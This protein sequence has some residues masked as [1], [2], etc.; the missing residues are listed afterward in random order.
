MAVWALGINHHTAPLDLRG[1]F[2]F[3]LDQIAPTLHGLR[4]SLSSASGRHPGVETAIISTCNRTEIYCAAEAPALDHTLDWL[5]H[6][7]GVSPAL[8]RSHSYSLENGLVARHAFRVASGL[9]SM[10]L[11]EAQIL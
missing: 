5:A 3:A 1:R 9:D 2:A 4:D 11:G 7:G 8:L 6:S 10:V